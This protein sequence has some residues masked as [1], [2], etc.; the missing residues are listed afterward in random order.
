MEIVG[1]TG[2]DV[3]AGCARVVTE[4]GADR[5]DALLRGAH[6]AVRMP[7]SFAAISRC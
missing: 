4:T 6:E 2:A 5:T 3:L 7:N 1:G